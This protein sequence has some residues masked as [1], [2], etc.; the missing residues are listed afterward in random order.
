MRKKRRKWLESLGIYPGMVVY[1]G[2][3]AAHLESVRTQGLV[4]RGAKP[5]QWEDEPSR[6]DMIYLTDSY[7]HFFGTKGGNLLTVAYEIDLSLLDPYRLFPDE[8][9]LAQKGLVAESPGES[10]MATARRMVDAF[11]NEWRNS[12]TE[13]GTCC[14]RGR[15][16]A[17][18]IRR[19]CRFDRTLN[20]KLALRWVAHSIG[21]QEHSE[22]GL[23]YKTLNTWMFADYEKLPVEWQPAP[24]DDPTA[25]DGITVFNLR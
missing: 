10:V 14:Y 8:D 25:R 9:Y 24:D 12:L 11:F 2:S 17:S 7:P 6:P 18:A 16:P 22:A 19:C 5:S 23:F 1:H 4:P 13:L 3:S 15:I 21:L 20:G